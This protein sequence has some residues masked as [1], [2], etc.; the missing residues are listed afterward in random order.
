MKPMCLY[1]TA[2]GKMLF[3]VNIFSEEASASQISAVWNIAMRDVSNCCVH[4]QQIQHATNQLA[5]ETNKHLKE[6]GSIP[7]PSSAPQQV[8]IPDVSLLA[9]NA[10][11]SSRFRHFWLWLL[12]FDLIH[13]G[14]SL[15]LPVSVAQRQQK[16]QRDRLMSDFSAALNNFQAV[17]RRAAEKEKETVARARGGS[18]L[19]VSSASRPQAWPLFKVCL[20]K[21]CLLFFRLMTVFRMKSWFHLISKFT[22]GLGQLWWSGSVARLCIMST[23]KDACVSE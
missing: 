22:H 9:E 5:K 4:R 20:T 11:S 19:S 12:N 21:I 2:L 7:L 23:S 15:H 8:N 13:V 6:L 17:Q 10:A 14:L 3:V 18:R 16:I 1:P